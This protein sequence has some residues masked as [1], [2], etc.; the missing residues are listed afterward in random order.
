MRSAFLHTIYSQRAFGVTGVQTSVPSIL[1]FSLDGPSSDT[2]SRQIDRRTARMSGLRNN[3]ISP[4]ASN[5]P[6]TPNKTITSGTSIALLIKSGFKMVVCWIHD[7]CTSRQQR[8]ASAELF[9]EQEADTTRQ[10]PY[11][12]KGLRR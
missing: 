11:P 10:R 3:S 12:K 8:K 9:G 7:E 5:P 2:H 6:N 4:N 1:K